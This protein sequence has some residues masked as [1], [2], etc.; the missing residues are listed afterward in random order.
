TPSRE[1]S[2]RALPPWLAEPLAATRYTKRVVAHV[3]LSRPP[4]ITCAGYAFPRGYVPGV[5]AVE[6]QH[7]RVPGRCPEGRGM[8]SVYFDGQ[9]GAEADD[10]VLQRRAVEAVEQLFPETRGAA[11]FVH[12]LRWD[13]GTGVFPVGRLR[14]MIEVLRQLGEWQEPVELAGGYL[15]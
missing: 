14:Q 12:L 2:G 3:A 6:L 1:G 7:H 5:G 9:P 8:V 15:D 13:V 11:L 10:G 4:E